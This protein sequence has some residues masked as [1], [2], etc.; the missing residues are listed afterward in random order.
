M[1]QSLATTSAA[2]STTIGMVTVTADM[3]D[4]VSSAATTTYWWWSS[5]MKKQILA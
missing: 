4:E 5:N 3:F 1:A 2:L